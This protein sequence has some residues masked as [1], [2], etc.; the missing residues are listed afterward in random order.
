[1][2]SLVSIRLNDDLFREMKA[3][4][5]MLHLSQTDY[6]R[7]AI[8]IMNDEIVK[9]QRRRRLKEASLLVRKESMKINAEFSEVEHDPED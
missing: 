9:K 1:M 3:N 6:I 4:A 5:Q 2:T 8:E 7:K